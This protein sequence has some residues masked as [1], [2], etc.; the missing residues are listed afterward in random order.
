MKNCP[1]CLREGH[2]TYCPP[3]RKRLFAGKKVSHVLTFSRPVYNQAKLVATG[4]RLSISGIQTKMS[5][6]LREGRLEMTETGGQYILKPIPHGEFRHL[7]AIPVNEHLTMQIARQVF[8]ISVAENALVE[9]QGGEV[10]YL[11][12]RFDVQEDGSRHLQE[13]F[14]Q[15]ASRSEESHGK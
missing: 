13:D 14:A 6:A 10:A 12:R 15:I 7:D 4:A 8:G 9:F 2:D 11:A 3:C 1:G 5:L